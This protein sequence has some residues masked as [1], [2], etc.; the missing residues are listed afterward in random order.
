MFE[1]NLEFEFN[2]SEDKLSG[3][4]ALSDLFNNDGT[5]E[6]DDL[7]MTQRICQSGGTAR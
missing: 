1:V 2:S 3:S 4:D 5:D 6:S 7:Y